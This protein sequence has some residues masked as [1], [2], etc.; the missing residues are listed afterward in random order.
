MSRDIYERL[1]KLIDMHALGC[2]PAPEIIDILKILFTEDEARV[3]LGLGFRPFAV[4][5]IAGRAGVEAGEA[6]QHLES[7]A[8]K[9]LV[10][11]REK[12]GSWGYALLNVINFFENPYRKGL[13]DET[14]K[15]LTPLWK[16]YRTTLAPALG[17]ETTS[18]ARAVADCCTS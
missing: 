8:N 11:A 7:L 2:P 15:R 6:G 4:S 18:I 1:R 16:K 13:P 12:N 14:I 5:E 10:F 3:A 9:G 17:G